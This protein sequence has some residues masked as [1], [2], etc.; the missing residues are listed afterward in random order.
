MKPGH[1]TSILLAVSIL[2]A[3]LAFSGNSR[4]KDDWLPVPPEDLALKDNP[5]NPGAHAMRA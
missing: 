5:L 4:A 2:T 3:L 1:K